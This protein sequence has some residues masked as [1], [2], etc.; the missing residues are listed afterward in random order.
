MIKRKLDSCRT[1]RIVRVARAAPG[2]GT[3]LGIVPDFPLGR[4]GL[5]IRVALGAC[6]SPAGSDGPRWD[7]VTA[8]TAAVFTFVLRRRSSPQRSTRSRSIPQGLLETLRLARRRSDGRLPDA[9]VQ[10]VRSGASPQIQTRGSA[11]GPR[12]ADGT[13]K[14]SEGIDDSR[15]RIVDKSLEKEVLSGPDGRSFERRKRA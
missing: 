8:T 13:R 15:A 1:G 2:L 6:P 14:R 9:R 11:E 3:L 12:S 10:L 5:R 4:S 7:V